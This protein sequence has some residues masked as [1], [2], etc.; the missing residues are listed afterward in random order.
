MES[1]VRIFVRNV[2]RI[3]P[4]FPASHFG[5]WKLAFSNLGLFQAYLLAIANE[6]LKPDLNLAKSNFQVINLGEILMSS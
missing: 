5:T 4:N 1:R 2:G 3:L 6:I